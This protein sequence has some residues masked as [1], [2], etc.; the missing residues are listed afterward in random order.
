MRYLGCAG[1]IVALAVSALAP[2]AVAKP[3]CPPGTEKGHYCE[4]HPH[5]HPHGGGGGSGD[6]G[7]SSGSPSGGVAVSP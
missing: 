7:D 2:G 3:H 1:V 5:H 6:S 4:P